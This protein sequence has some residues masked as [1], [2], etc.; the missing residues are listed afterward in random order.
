MHVFMQ[1]PQVFAAAHQL[2][3]ECFSGI[4]REVE[5][6]KK[7]KKKNVFLQVSVLICYN[8]SLVQPLGVG[9]VTLQSLGGSTCACSCGGKVKIPSGGGK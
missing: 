1:I 7:K 3:T 6:A 5:K 9:R 8:L 2:T 4:C